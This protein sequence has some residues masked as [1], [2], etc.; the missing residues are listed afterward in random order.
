MGE[1]GEKVGMGEQI[2]TEKKT[3]K[4]VLNKWNAERN[5]ENMLYHCYW[6][7]ER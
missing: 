7:K 4:K 3:R 1:G 6:I 2:R 5:G